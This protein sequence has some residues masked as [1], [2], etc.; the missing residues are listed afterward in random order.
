M[1]IYDCVLPWCH[2]E[3]Y[4]RGACC[5]DCWADRR[6]QLVG[7]P[8]LYAMTYAMLTP[9]SRLQEITTINVNVDPAAPVNLVALDAL[10]YGYQRLAGW[11]AWVYRLGRT[12][13]PTLARYSTGAGFALVVG[14]L[15]EHD[16][17]LATRDYA[18]EYVLDVWTAYRRLAVQ[19]LPTG[20]R[21]LDVPCPDCGMATVLTRHADEYA[22]CLT[23]SRTWPHSKLP[24]L[25]QAQ[26]TVRP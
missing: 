9:G 25:R 14:T 12:G 17:R 5:D 22:V 8:D 26:R 21:H 18:G 1:N 20:P 11:A 4:A 23:C 3:V 13:A 6:G 19:C 7:L 15:L 16:H 24:H 10:Q 2:A